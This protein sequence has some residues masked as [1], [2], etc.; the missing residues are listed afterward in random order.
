MSRLQAYFS[1][2]FIASGLGTDFHEFIIK[3][4]R[5]KSKTEEA[6]HVT[7]ELKNLTHKMGLPD[8]S[9]AKMRDYLIRLMHC[10]MLGYAVDFSIIY[11]IMASQSGETASDRRAGYLACTLFLAHD[12]ELGI[13]LVNTLQRD[14]KSQNYLDRCSALN[15]ICY[16]EH[17]EIVDNLLTLVVACMEFPKQ[18]VR[19]KA[20]MALYFLFERSSIPIDR[21]EPPLRLALED[22]DSSVVFASLSIWKLILVDHGKRCKDLLPTFFDI[23]RKIIEN[24]IHKSFIYHGVYAPWAQMDCLSIYNIYLDLNIGSPKEIYI[25]IM[26]CLES[27]DKKVDAAFAVVLECVKLL[28]V[29]DPTLLECFSN[30]PDQ[31]N[32][33][34]VLVNYLNASNL[35]LKYLG[36]V[37][38]MYVDHSFWKDDWLDGTLIART[39]RTCDDTITAQAIENLDT[40]IDP[41]ILVHISRDLID[42]LKLSENQPLAY[43]LLNRIMEHYTDRDAWFIETVIE[44]LAV[45]AKRLDDD[46]VETQ[47]SVLKEALLGEVQD[48]KLRESSVNIIYKLIESNSSNTFSPLWIQFAFWTLGENGYLSNLYSEIDIM[49]QLEKCLIIIKDDDLQTCGLQA[50]KRCV[51]R[52][53]IWLSGLEKILKE[54]KRSPVPEKQQIA[55]ELLDIISDVEFEKQLQETDYTLSTTITANPNKP[56]TINHFSNNGTDRSTSLSNVQQHIPFIQETID[57]NSAQMTTKE[58]GKLWVEYKIEE[59]RV[60]ECSVQDCSKLAKRLSKSWQIEIIQVI[61]QE[62][63]AIETSSAVLLI[64]V[65]MLPQNLFQLTLKTKLNPDQIHT[66]LTTRQLQ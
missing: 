37:G 56:T 8:V 32:P 16:L 24:R 48:T 5:A 36:L 44:I 18:V 2:E 14:L 31:N 53:K 35:N 21:L 34:E 54:Y 9:S 55:R 17:T 61:G 22:K 60:F 20:I 33:F 65:A 1:S 57:S 26:E 42:A 38:M 25:M 59:K 13:M 30:E 11:A 27:M 45:T 64:H 62:F 10:Y 28:S 52:S 15:A 12:H 3:V 40:I 58:F 46:Y 39:L 6:S 63:I 66:F 4:T 41:K 51:L 47:C 43:W 7:E 23:H 50:I 29:M 19:K 49:K